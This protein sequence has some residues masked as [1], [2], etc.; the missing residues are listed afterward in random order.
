MSFSVG[1]SRFCSVENV[2]FIFAMRM[3]HIRFVENEEWNA[4]D[5][6]RA[7]TRKQEQLENCHKLKKESDCPPRLFTEVL[8]VSS[9]FGIIMR[10]LI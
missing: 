8:H 9:Q 1:F 3:S 2:R 4:R 6:A 5:S 10:A 7:R